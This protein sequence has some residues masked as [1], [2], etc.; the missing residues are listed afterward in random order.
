VRL[1]Q[2][3]VIVEDT[4][5]GLPAAVRATIDNALANVPSVGSAGTGLGLALVKRICRYMEATLVF[6][7]RAGG[8]SVFEII[9]PI[10]ITKS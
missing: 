7:D 8:G 10:A 9:F 1:G 4:G 2:R 6:S 5:P 3:S